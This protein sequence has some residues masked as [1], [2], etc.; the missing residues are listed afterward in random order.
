MLEVKLGEQLTKYTES[1]KQDV[2]VMWLIH[3][4]LRELITFLRV[5]REDCARADM[6]RPGGF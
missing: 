3:K 4:D 2:V 1:A 6:F 5:G